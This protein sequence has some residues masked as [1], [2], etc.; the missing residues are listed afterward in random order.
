MPLLSVE[1][2]RLVPLLTDFNS[3]GVRNRQ[4]LRISDLA[5]DRSVVALPENNRRKTKNAQQNHRCSHP[6]DPQKIEWRK[7]PAFTGSGR[8]LQVE[9]ET[10]PLRVPETVS[11]KKSRS[12]NWK[13]LKG[14]QKRQ[15]EHHCQCLSVPPSVPCGERYVGG[16]RHQH[17]F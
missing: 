4:R 5:R 8:S 14:S 7:R 2:E 10:L 1:T 3:T 15:S 16:V 12:N 9:K 17:A 6:T 11:T 13:G